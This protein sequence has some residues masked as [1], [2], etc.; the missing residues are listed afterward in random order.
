MTNRPDRPLTW[1]RGSARRLALIETID[2]RIV[3]AATFFFGD[4]LAVAS[5]GGESVEFVARGRLNIDDMPYTAKGK[6]AEAALARLLSL[7]LLEKARAS[8]HAESRHGK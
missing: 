3:R 7:A 4:S 8:E 1:D 6:T 2:Q 5:N